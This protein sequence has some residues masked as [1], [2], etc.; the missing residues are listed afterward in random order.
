MSGEMACRGNRVKQAEGGND[1]TVQ[2]CILYQDK[3]GNRE[4]RHMDMDKDRKGHKIGQA[5]E[6][7]FLFLK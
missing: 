1:K 5:E 4:Q 6:I 2:F 7:I 3:K